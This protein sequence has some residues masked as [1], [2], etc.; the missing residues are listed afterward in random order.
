MKKPLYIFVLLLQTLFFSA[1]NTKADSAE[2][3][4]LFKEY[5]AVTGTDRSKAF[6]ILNKIEKKSTVENN[7]FYLSEAYVY[8]AILYYYDSNYDSSKICINSALTFSKKT[9]NYKVEMRAYNL[10]GAIYYNQGD[11]KNTEKYYTEKIKVA[12]KHHDTASIYSTYYNM[13]LV[14]FQQGN[15]LKS[16]DFNFKALPYFERV[17]DTFNTVSSLQ[18]IGFTYMSLEDIPSSLTFYYKAAKLAKGYKDKYQLAGI[19]IDM[20][21]AYSNL[22]KNDSAISYLDL[23]LKLSAKHNDDFHFTIA[24]NNKADYYLKKKNYQQALVLSKEAE[25]LN[26][27]DNRRLALCEV[28]SSMSNAYYHLNELDSSLKYARKGYSIGLET[29]QSK[30]VRECTKVLSYIFEAR[31]NSD[32]ALKYYKLYTVFNDTLKQESQLRGI[33][34]KEFMFEKKNQED[35]RANEK[36][37]ADTK[38]EK[39]K[40]INL[41]VIIASILL[42]I[43]LLVGIV[44][45]RQKQKVNAVVL[46]QKKLLEEKNK[47]VADSINYASRIQ[48]SIMLNE[49]GTKEILPNSFVLYM[50][51]DIVS[52]DFYWISTITNTTNKELSENLVITAVVDCTGHGVP[53]AF[54]SLIGST[55]LNQTLTNST[56][57]SCAQALDF[58][59]EELPKNI[60]SS[61]TSGTIKDGMEIS[62]AL[63]DLEKKTLN[64]AGANNN[65][66]LIR[67]GQLHFYAGDKK[68]I[69]QGYE[70]KKFT[71]NFIA[72]QTNDIIYMFTDGYPDQFGGEKGKKFKYKQLE[73]I[74]LENSSKPLDKQKEILQQKFL[75]WKG[76]LEQ[77]D[78]V[79]ILGIKI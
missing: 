19:Y 7:F 31:K 30:M 8:K 77:V 27:K 75:A 36:L 61:S 60:K 2:Y 69:G 78:D 24:L 74:L 65:L 45:Y 10:L 66:Y 6:N 46:S 3:K 13:G 25:K 1:Q 41:I 37:I 23:A 68:P 67:N 16:A 43:F 52:G 55:L 33:A 9:N 54:M 12:E 76:A 79:C 56:I 51:K 58:L 42:A 32:S 29:E 49:Q 28:Y 14:Y 20:A 26:L 15:Y 73:E 63:F 11:F 17:K 21:T 72:L 50:P 57:N 44:N 38:L 39:Q 53:G 18:A 47:E 48:K 71:D 70:T 22:N 40:Q 4:A 59:N 34:Q 35:L 62:M 64:F 5:D